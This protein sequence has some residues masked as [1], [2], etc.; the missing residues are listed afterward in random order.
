MD[1]YSLSYWRRFNGTLRFRPRLCEN[2]KS[3]NIRG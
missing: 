2:A 1:Q 3:Q